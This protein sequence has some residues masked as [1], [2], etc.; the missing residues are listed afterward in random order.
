MDITVTLNVN[1]PDVGKLAE[2][3]LDLTVAIR[4]S[5]RTD[6]APGAAAAPTTATAPA[7]AAAPKGTRKRADLKD[8]SASAPSAEVP[9]SSGPEI[10]GLEATP[11]ATSGPAVPGLEAA[12]PAAPA[13]LPPATPGAL[14]AEDVR[15]VLREFLSKDTEKRKVV[16]KAILVEHG[17]ESVQALKPE[18]FASVIA[19]VKAASAS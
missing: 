13:T 5:G 15:V 1:A 4:N 19:K 7:T 14:T 8:V 9:T 18:H 10:P 2:A 3:I 6:L 11:P 12:A 16:G 17:V